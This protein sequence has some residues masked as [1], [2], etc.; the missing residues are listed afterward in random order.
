MHIPYI[1]F[2][3]SYIGKQYDPTLIINERTNSVV[4][5]PFIINVVGQLIN[6]SKSPKEE[7]LNIAKWIRKWGGGLSNIIHIYP[8]WDSLIK[9]ACVATPIYHEIWVK[10]IKRYPKYYPKSIRKNDEIQILKSLLKYWKDEGRKGRY[11]GPY[12]IDKDQIEYQLAVEKS[13]GNDHIFE[14][15]TQIINS[16]IYDYQLEP[17]FIAC[18]QSIPDIIRQKKQKEEEQ[19]QKEQKQEEQKQ[20]QQKQNTQKKK[21]QQQ[22]GNQQ[23]S[24][25]RRRRRKRKNRN[26]SKME[27]T[28]QNDHHTNSSMKECVQTSKYIKSPQTA[29]INPTGA[30]PDP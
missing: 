9:K 10:W 13:Y 17:L 25:Q 19:K 3:S 8:Q 23:K 6:D 20:Q 28:K 27:V 30:P 12:I 15:P 11:L 22:E 1:S 5:V 24:K 18:G 26:T 21:K 2:S 4:F 14:T 16:A 7:L 29:P